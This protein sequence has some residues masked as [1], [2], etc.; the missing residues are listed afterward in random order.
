[1]AVAGGF[2][3]SQAAWVASLQGAQGAGGARG[4]D[5]RSAYEVAVAGGFSG[6]QAAW[7]ASLKGATGA[8]GA[9]GVKGDTGA[10]GATGGVGATGAKGADGLTTSVN[11]I[12][13][14]NGN[15]ALT[16]AS[17]PLSVTDSRK[18]DAVLEAVRSEAAGKV[19]WVQLYVNASPVSAF[20]PQI[21]QLDLAAYDM[22]AVV[23]YENAS[24]WGFLKMEMLLRGREARIVAWHNDGKQMS[25]TVATTNT[26]VQF[27]DCWVRNDNTAGV[28]TA[29]NKY[30]V[31]YRIYG[32]KG[33]SA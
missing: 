16:G 17:I 28:G 22:V 31:P 10:T 29:D 21:I 7:V 6:S 11:G 13:Q 30:M 27:Y 19:D 9:Q 33:V 15:V 25:R 26:G 2:S 12:V 3:G 5:G 32:V 1:V 8:Q 14:V 23:C 4:A 20:V 24:Q 18:L